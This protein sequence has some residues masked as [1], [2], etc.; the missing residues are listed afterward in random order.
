MRFDLG[1]KSFCKHAL[2]PPHESFAERLTVDCGQSAIGVTCTEMPSNTC[3]L[4]VKSQP[5]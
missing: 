2:Q 1:R 4:V 5:E 3:D